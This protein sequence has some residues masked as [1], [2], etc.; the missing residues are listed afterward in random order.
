MKH[1][2]RWQDWIIM[3]IGIWVFVT[4]WILGFSNMNFAWDPFFT[5]ALLVIFSIWEL[6]NKR[7]WEE[8][9]N[10]IILFIIKF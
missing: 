2:Q 4:P 6:S 8:W 7:I 9:S 5:G 3:I 1:A 10:L